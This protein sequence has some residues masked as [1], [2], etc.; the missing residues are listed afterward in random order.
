MDD[1]YFDDVDK[2]ELLRQFSRWEQA[3]KK[4][5]LAKKRADLREALLL[6]AVGLVM[7]ITFLVAGSRFLRPTSPALD[8]SDV[9]ALDHRVTQLSTD[10]LASNAKL[11]SFIAKRPIPAAGESDESR[12][13]KALDQRLSRLELAISNNPEKAL[14]IPLLRRD[15]DALSAKVADNQ[16]RSDAEIREVSAGVT[17]ILWTLIS[18]MALLILSGA[19]FIA[20]Q[21]LGSKK[22]DDAEP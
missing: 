17:K 15:V 2:E 9:E 19:G 20:R 1:K 6:I 3:R 22:G 7:T 18:A 8:N 21:L 5:D 14:S 13:M 16:S 10:V 12:E 11:A 4:A